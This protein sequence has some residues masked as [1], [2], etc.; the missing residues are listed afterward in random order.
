LGQYVTNTPRVATP[1][2]PQ[3]ATLI[4]SMLDLNLPV[5]GE[6]PEADAAPP[7]EIFEAGTGMGCLTLHLARALHGANPP[8]PPELRKALCAAPYAKGRLL[9]DTATDTSPD[10]GPMPHELDFSSPDLQAQLETYLSRRRAVVHTLDINPSTSRQA[11]G[12]IRKFRRAQYLL[13][14]DFHVS[15]IRSYLE[16]RLA[17]SGGEPFLAHAVL[18]LPSATE[19][20]D[21]VVRS[22]RPDGKLVMF[23]PSITQAIEAVVWAEESTQ[24]VYMDR[25]I[26]LPSS[27]WSEGFHDGVGGREWDIR[28]VMPRKYARESGGETVPEKDQ[29]ESEEEVGKSK[30]AIVCRP[31]VGNLVGGG[32]FLTIFTRRMVHQEWD[33]NPRESPGGKSTDDPLGY[34]VKEGSE[35][36]E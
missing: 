7:V 15:T 14:I 31:K 9:R 16:S 12:V 34:G 20:A 3:D 26:E 18:D 23:T 25:V 36:L 27:T 30:K 29:D 8:V 22:L 17:Q 1:I 5:P 11:H 4:V 24:P 2:Y 13:D 33:D 28:S 10:L 32:G 21:L 19:H 6:D 35:R